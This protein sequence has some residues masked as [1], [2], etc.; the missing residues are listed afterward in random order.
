MA[1]TRRSRGGSFTLA[2]LGAAATT[3]LVPLAL[4][5][6]LKRH[7]RGRSVKRVMKYR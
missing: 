5:L 7:Q 1:K 6:G 2:S 4:Y 3:A